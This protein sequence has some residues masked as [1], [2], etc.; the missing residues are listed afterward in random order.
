MNT[1]EAI[2]TKLKTKFLVVYVDLALQYSGFY[3][4]DRFSAMDGF[5]LSGRS[6]V[7]TGPWNQCLADITHDIEANRK[8]A[9]TITTA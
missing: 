8:T 5:E 3:D 6:I 2:N 7:E 9:M 4:Q 1:P